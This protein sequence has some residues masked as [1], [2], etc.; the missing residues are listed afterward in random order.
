MAK[1]WTKL[2][3]KYLSQDEIGLFGLSDGTVPNSDLDAEQ[4][5]Q[6]ENPYTGISDIGTQP[7]EDKW[8]I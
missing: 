8:N 1:D 7:Y 6:T 4:T 3:K 2:I 5:I